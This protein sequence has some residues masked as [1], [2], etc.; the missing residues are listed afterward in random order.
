MMGVNYYEAEDLKINGD[1]SGNLPEEILE[2]IDD[3]VESF[4]AE[5][6]KT[7]YFDVNNFHY[8]NCFFEKR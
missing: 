7:K 3:V 6:K 8:S 2:I 1:E 5:I 4:F